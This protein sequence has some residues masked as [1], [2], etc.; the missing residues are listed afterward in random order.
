MVGQS[1]SPTNVN[2][3][4]EG[5]HGVI[6]HSN[7]VNSDD[8]VDNTTT[9]TDNHSFKFKVRRRRKYREEDTHQKTIGHKTAIS[10]EENATNY[11]VGLTI[12]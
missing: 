3:D 1:V 11:S 8:N 12:N 5:S 6:N 2:S 4:D 7:Y 9:Q 10:I